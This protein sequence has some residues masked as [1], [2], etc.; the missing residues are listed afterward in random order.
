MITPHGF[1][2]LG[3]QDKPEDKRDIKLGAGAA[4][5]YSFPPTLNSLNAITAAVE[6]Q[7]QQ[8]ACGAHAGSSLRGILK[9]AHFT[10]RFTW[11]DIKSFDGMPVEWGTDIRSIFKSITKQGALDFPLLGNDASLSL[12]DYVK[13]AITQAMR[14]NAATH[15]GMGYG[16]ITD[17]TFNGIKQF[18][19]DHGPSI[20]LMRV[21][22]EM[23]TAPNGSASWQEIDILPMRPPKKVISGHF[24]VIHSYDENNVYFLNSWSDEWG[25][26]GHGYFGA[27]YMP[28][29]NDVG[30]LFPLAFNHDLQ[31]GMTDLDVQRLQAILNRNPK[32]QVALVGDGSPGHETTYFGNLTRAAVIKFQ[33]L[34]SI[35]PNVGYVGPLTRCV[36]NGFV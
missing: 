33:T 4:P 18:L 10:P 34:Y 17:L 11:A 2:N 32:T 7:K 29:I 3:G 20:M 21:G 28:F 19:Y 23:W 8:P 25:R 36:L 15:S 26:K 31:L 9:A 6:Y 14:A 24:V 13:P 27:N 22:E 30:T 1:D 35:T 12:Q 16:F 5:V